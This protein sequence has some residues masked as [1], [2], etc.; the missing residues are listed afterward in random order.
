MLKTK[1]HKLPPARIAR[2]RRG[3]LANMR[4]LLGPI[5]RVR[6]GKTELA[7]ASIAGS[8]VLVT[9]LMLAAFG[10]AN[11]NG[12]SE[13]YSAKA[14]A[15]ASALESEAESESKPK[16]LVTLDD[17]CKWA[18]TKGEACEETWARAMAGGEQDPWDGEDDWIVSQCTWTRYCFDETQPEGA[19]VG[20]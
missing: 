9:G 6:L 10:A 8:I 11:Q 17:T 4:S 12:L 13:Q 3:A 2:T 18:R 19:A 16:V 5:A 1:R 20:K 15:P 14:P 7:A